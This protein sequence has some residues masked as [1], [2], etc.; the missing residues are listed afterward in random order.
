MVLIT[1]CK[2]LKERLFYMQE[3]VV[4]QWTIE[5]LDHQID[6]KLYQKQGALPNNFASTLPENLRDNFI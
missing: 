5:I 2:D 1:R 3:A 6:A 4:N